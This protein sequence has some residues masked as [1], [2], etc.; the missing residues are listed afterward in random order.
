MGA[1]QSKVRITIPKNTCCFPAFKDESTIF[2]T[3][4]QVEECHIQAVK[5]ASWIGSLVAS[6]YSSVGSIAFSAA[7]ILF[8]FLLQRITTNDEESD[9][10]NNNEDGCCKKSTGNSG[11]TTMEEA[12]IDSKVSAAI[13]KKSV[14]ELQAKL[15][16]INNR[17]QRLLSEISVEDRRLEVVPAIQTCEEVLQLFHDATHVFRLNPLVTSPFIVTFAGI[18]VAVAELSMVLIPSY[19]GPLVGEMN[20]L[21]QTLGMYK[22]ACIRTRMENVKFR[23][24]MPGSM[25]DVVAGGMSETSYSME[26]LLLKIRSPTIHSPST[27]QYGSCSSLETGCIEDD[28]LDRVFNNANEAVAA[29]RGELEDEYSKFFETSLETIAKFSGFENNDSCRMGN[30]PEESS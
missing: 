1:Q 16:V 5:L 22:K 26:D 28:E 12:L 8:T 19:K 27:S 4:K 10:F 24:N 20:L 29:Y 30:C 17:Y 23:G 14:C 15:C 13:A 9:E 2:E 3:V 25:L 18:F 11:G 6:P 21:S 7:T